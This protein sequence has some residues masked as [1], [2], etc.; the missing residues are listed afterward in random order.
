M[1]EFLQSVKRAAVEAVE[2]G[3]PAAP[4]VG[5]VVSEDPLLVRLNQR[6]TLTSRR[7]MFLR[8]MEEPRVGDRLG[9]LRFVGGQRYIVLG[10]LR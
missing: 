6:V 2:A 4:C 1:T 7:L 5:L 3:Q 8:H 10:K 9:L